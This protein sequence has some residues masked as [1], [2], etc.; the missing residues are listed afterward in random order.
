[1]TTGRTE[2][3]K[4]TIVW[5]LAVT[6]DMTIISGNSFNRT[7]IPDKLADNLYRY[8]QCC[9]SPKLFVLDPDPIFLR[10]LD[11]DPEHTGT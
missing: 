1:M 9:G 10:V 2:K 11:T 4:E 5:S 3:N 6:D 7:F 8:R